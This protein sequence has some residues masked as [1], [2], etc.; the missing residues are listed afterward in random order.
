MEVDMRA[1]VWETHV[2]RK[3]Y[4]LREERLFPVYTAHIVLLVIFT[5]NRTAVQISASTFVIYSVM[6]E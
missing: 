1:A 3:I 4:T 5:L 2:S 6:N